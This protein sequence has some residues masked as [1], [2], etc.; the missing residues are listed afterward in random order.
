VARGTR[1][2]NLVLNDFLKQE[3]KSMTELSCGVY[4]GRNVA[5]YPLSL[6]AKLTSAVLWMEKLSMI[7]IFLSS[8]LANG[9]LLLINSTQTAN[10]KLPILVL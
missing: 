7:T 1:T 5:P 6:K 4:G 9:N 3:K 8:K 10:L 2:S